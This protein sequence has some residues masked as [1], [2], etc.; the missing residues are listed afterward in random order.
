MKK[1]RKLSEEHKKKLSLAKKGKML[2]ANNH[3]FGRK[4]TK[5]SRKKMSLAVLKNPTRYWLGKKRTQMSAEKHFA[6]KGEKGSYRTKHLWVENNF[7]KPSKCENCL[8][9]NFIGRQIHWANISGKYLR[10]R[11]D[12]KRLCAK[13]HGEFDKLNGFRKRKLHT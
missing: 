9:D 6:W 5:E 12:W 2:G 8:I 4:H 1:R 11:S 10:V 13:C 7:G 3:F